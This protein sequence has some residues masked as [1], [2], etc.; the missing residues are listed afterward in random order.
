MR[1]VLVGL[2]VGRAAEAGLDRE[3][4]VDELVV[5]D[6]AEVEGVAANIFGTLGQHAQA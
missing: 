3:E 1:G 4:E 6:G 5:A 2:V